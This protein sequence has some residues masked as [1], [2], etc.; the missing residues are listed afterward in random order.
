MI[1]GNP[2]IPEVFLA[3]KSLVIDIPGISAGDAQTRINHKH[4]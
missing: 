3:R 1:P 2:E 4:F